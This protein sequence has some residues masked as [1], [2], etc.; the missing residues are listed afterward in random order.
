SSL[1]AGGHCTAGYT[2]GSELRPNRCQPHRDDRGKACGARKY[3][4]T[5]DVARGWP[6]S[7]SMDRCAALLVMNLCGRLNGMTN[8]STGMLIQPTHG[9]S[10]L[11]RSRS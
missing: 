8:Y 10:T 6:I 3:A 7:I 2:D 4:T 11:R 5:G 9:P 1:R